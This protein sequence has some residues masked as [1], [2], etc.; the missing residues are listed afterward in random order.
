MDFCPERFMCDKPAEFKN[1]I[2][3][4]FRPFSTGTMNVSCPQRIYLTFEAE[5]FA[6]SGPESG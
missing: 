6:V 1:D 2:M 5:L 3:T 4:G